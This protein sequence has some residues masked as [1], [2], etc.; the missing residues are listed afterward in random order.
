MTKVIAKLR[1]EERKI[2]RAES[3]EE[4]YLKAMRIKENRKIKKPSK[5]SQ[6]DKQMSS[7]ESSREDEKTNRKHHNQRHKSSKAYERKTSTYSGAKMLHL[8]RLGTHSKQ[9]SHS[10]WKVGMSKGDDRSKTKRLMQ[11]TQ[12]KMRTRKGITDVST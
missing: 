12:A 5:T 8:S 7:E 10:S 11:A 9:M 1:A 4:S 6:T 3:E 2:A